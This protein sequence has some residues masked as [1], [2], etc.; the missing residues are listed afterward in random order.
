MLD[1]NEQQG[2][3]DQ[4]A[5]RPVCSITPQPAP[6]DA[7]PTILPQALVIEPELQQQAEAPVIPAAMPHAPT[8]PDPA[9]PK[10]VRAPAVTPPALPPTERRV[11]RDRGTVHSRPK[12]ADEYSGLGSKKA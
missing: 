10:V 11:P 2:V 4:L 5:N 7:Q 1:F 3:H 8:Q 12:F 9:L 6:A